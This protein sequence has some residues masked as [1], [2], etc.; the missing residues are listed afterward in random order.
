[1]FTEALS[2][3]VLKRSQ[4]NFTACKQ[5]QCEKIDDSVVR[6]YQIHILRIQPS[7]YHCGFLMAAALQARGS[8]CDRWNNW[9]LPVQPLACRAASAVIHRGVLLDPISHR[10]GARSDRCRLAHEEFSYESES[11]NSTITSCGG[12]IGG[13]KLHARSYFRQCHCHRHCQS[14][15]TYDSAAP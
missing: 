3:S 13:C 15:K 6:S 4:N 8:K 2:R 9:V 5:N 11:A 10:L 14:A 1:M 12:A 7:R